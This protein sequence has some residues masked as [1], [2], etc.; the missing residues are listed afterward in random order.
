MNTICASKAKWFRTEDGATDVDFIRAHENLTPMG[1]IH[2]PMSSA[3][4]LT[5]FRDKANSL[6][7]KFRKETG[8]LLKPTE[9]G[10]ANR[11][12]FIAEVEDPTH[13]DY[14]LSVGFRNFG[15]KTLS[16]SGMCGNSIFVCENG[17]CTSVVKPSR[18][19]HTIGNVDNNRIDGKIDHIFDRFCKDAGEI[20]GQIALMK[21]TKITDDI[22]G[23]FVRSAIKCN[24]LGGRNL[25]RI[26]EDLENPAYNSHNDNSVFRLMN[27]CSKVSTHNV[28]NP[29]QGA[30]LSRYCNN[31]IMTIIKPD[32]VPLGDAVEETDVVEIGDGVA[33]VA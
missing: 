28:P 1:V 21:D 16:F 17:V 31:L 29:N 13:P 33:I 22:V 3:D 24:Y 6:G 23:K 26:L 18:M 9:N 8:A 27:A 14:A 11:Y 10:G 32:F 2:R 7:L 12:M 4:I 19:R 25:M 5:K 20:H 15:D 30:M